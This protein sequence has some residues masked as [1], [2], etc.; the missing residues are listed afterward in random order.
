MT[1]K[2]LKTI[3]DPN[4]RVYVVWLPI[5]RKDN[6]GRVPKAAATVS[7]IRATNYWDGEKKL[8]RDFAET[9]EFTDKSQ[10]AWDIYL[11]YGKDTKWETTAPKPNYWMHQLEDFPK[12]NK[13]DATKLSKEIERYLTTNE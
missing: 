6:E 9:L 8:A 4:L 5:L 12:D 11:V 1:K 13:L 2:V 10:P 7:D 3:K